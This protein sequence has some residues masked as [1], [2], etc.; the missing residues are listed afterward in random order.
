MQMVVHVQLKALLSHMVERI[1][2]YPSLPE[3]DIPL[4]D[5]ILLQAVEQR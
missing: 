1:V 2:H 3:V 4:M 5:G